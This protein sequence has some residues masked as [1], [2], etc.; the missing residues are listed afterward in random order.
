MPGRVSDW[1]FRRTGG[2]PDLMKGSVR[3]DHIQL[4]ELGLAPTLG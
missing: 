1:A 3:T 4:E 2:E